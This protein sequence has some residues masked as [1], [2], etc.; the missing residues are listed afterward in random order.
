[1]RVVFRAGTY[2]T[3]S[4]AILAGLL[5]HKAFGISSRGFSIDDRDE[6][7]FWRATGH[8]ETATVLVAKVKG[9]PKN[10]KGAD[11]KGLVAAVEADLKE[12]TDKDGVVKEVVPLAHL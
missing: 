7:G 6:T 5:S 12:R 4:K 1:M 8:I 11:V 10:P 2:R 3:R 9:S